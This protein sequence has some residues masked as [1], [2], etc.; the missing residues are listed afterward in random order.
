MTERRRRGVDASR[1]N[2]A[3]CLAMTALI[4]CALGF[5]AFTAVVLPRIRWVILVLA[6]LPVFFLLHYLTWGRWMSR[7]REEQDEH[8]PSATADD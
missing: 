3:T 7:L 4:A 2:A 6:A 1:R 8:F 5:L